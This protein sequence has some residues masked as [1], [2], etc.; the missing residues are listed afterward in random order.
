MGLHF[1]PSAN[2]TQHLNKLLDAAANN[3]EKFD[4]YTHDTMPERYHFTHNT[5]IAPIYVVP[6]MGYA[7]TTS[8]EDTG[9]SIGVRFCNA[10]DYLIS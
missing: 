6:K 10:C 2:V 3:S 9:P 1:K 7:M 8:K 4:V 5:R